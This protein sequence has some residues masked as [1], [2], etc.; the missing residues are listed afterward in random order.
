[1]ERDLKAPLSPHEE[2]TL[3]RIWSLK[4]TVGCP[5]LI[6]GAN[7]TGRCPKASGMTAVA[8]EGE[9]AALV[10]HHVLGGRQR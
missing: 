1:M 10:A 9:A 5:S 2:V 8:D 6:L 7:G 4:T 3:R